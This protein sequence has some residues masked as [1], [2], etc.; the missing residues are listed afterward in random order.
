MATE[1]NE[2]IPTRRSLITRLKNWNDQDGWQR[3]FDTYWRMI[4]SVARRS[5]LSDADAQDVVQET[6]VGVA[7]R[8]PDFKYDPSIGSFKGWLAQLTRC[9][10]IDLLRKRNYQNK[11]RQFAK[12]EPLATSIAESE[13][14]P[15]DTG[16]DAVWDEE[17]NKHLMETA[18]EKAKRHVGPA[19]YQMFHFHVIKNV[20]AKE[21]AELLQVELPE[22]YYA[23]KKI[24]ELL[25]K[26]IQHLEQKML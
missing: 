26:E 19:Q 14:A 3:F 18:L 11:G 16:L 7:K 8:M 13:P 12:E 5:G 22:V 20:P 24:S 21:V 15:N 6:I 9:R 1:T 2:F 25:Q 4:Y 10:I 17:W 23:K